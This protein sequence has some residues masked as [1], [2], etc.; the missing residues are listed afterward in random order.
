[1]S[2]LTAA[3]VALGR[4]GVVGRLAALWNRELS[5]N[6]VKLTVAVAA[7]VGASYVVLCL[8]AVATGVYGYGFGD[9]YALWTSAVVV[10]DG[11]PLLN[12]DADALHA[13]Q[14]DLG[15]NPHGYNPFPYPPTW[16][17]AL[18]PL[19]GFSLP[20]AFALFMAP[21]V[22]LYLWAIA[23]G[24]GG[25]W[26]W[27]A[28]A[29]CAP[30]TGV[31]LISGQTGFLSGA[32]MIGGLRLA[33]SRPI[34]SGILFG[35]L[36]FKPQ[37]G[38]LVPVALIAA[39]LWR[40]IASAVATVLVGALASSLAF[41]FEVW[42]T[43]ARSIL[44]YGARFD[45][46]VGLMPTIY[47][48]ALEAHAPRSVALVAQLCVSIPVAIVV[49]RAFREGVTERA[50]A[51]LLLGA[52]LATPHAFNY[53]MPMTTAAVLAYLLLRYDGAHSVTLGEAFA[54]ILMLAL[55]FL[56]L[57]LRSEV[58][59]FTWAPQ[60]LLFV[61]LARSSA[62]TASAHRERAAEAPRALASAS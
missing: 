50:Q 46:V 34:L 62:W 3:P 6:A 1:M 19:G 33:A 23:G 41:G 37:L 32:L 21:S 51:L 24:R 11:S 57:A 4:Q 25:D 28:G 42:P 15:M 18:A 35:L 54:L 56:T 20:V 17:L 53:D 38:V 43:W 45:L 52:F 10:H 16:M 7:A 27:I 26:R 31:T 40:T 14:V 58:P 29:L 13:R 59:A 39:G 36:A 44:D 22:A 5:D 2:L 30:A 49:W 9:F 8:R 48:N 47:A 61:M 55:P 12:Y 60:A